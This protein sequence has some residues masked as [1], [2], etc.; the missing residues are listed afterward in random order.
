MENGPARSSA[1]SSHA[2]TRVWKMSVTLHLPTTPS[3][4]VSGVS[5]QSAGGPA[6]TFL[7]QKEKPI[8]RPLLSNIF[9]ND[10]DED[11]LACIRNGVVS[12][13]RGS[14]PAPVVSI[15]EASPQ[16]LCSVLG[17]SVQKGHGDAGAGP[18]KGNQAGEGLGKCAL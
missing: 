8:H 11:I 10:L 17:T 6:F 13:T 14:D 18:K 2:E 12:R 16:V 3:W 4:R 7:T 15:G 1:R 9:I 5:C